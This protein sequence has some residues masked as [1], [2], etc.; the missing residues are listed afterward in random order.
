VNRYGAQSMSAPL[1][2]VAVRRPPTALGDAD[3]AIWHYSA[4]VDVARA[5]DAH[6]V[7]VAELQRCGVEV[8]DIDIDA[9][10]LPDSVFTFDPSLVTERGAVILRMGKQL[11]RPE[12]ELHERYYRSVGV[13]IAGR[14]E[15]PGTVEGGDTLW[16]DETTLAVGRGFRTNDEG[17]DQLSRL[18][19]R[20]NVEVIAFDLPFHDGED[21]CMH[22][23]SLVSPLAADLA[24]VRLPLMPVRLVQLLGDRG[25]ELIDAPAKEWDASASISG[26]VLAVAPR[27][28]LMIDGLPDTRSALQRAGCTVSTFPGDELCL[29][30][31]GGPTC[32][33]R[34]VWRETPGRSDVGSPQGA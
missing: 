29:K 12:A 24:L 27:R 18:L 7:L 6:E 26:N 13:P 2:R 8:D 15:A 22:L 20:S 32:L 21:A 14:I 11:R 3:P 1:R 4:P 28:C 34:P 33:T 17:I 19:A 31:E 25:Y 23:L 5:R 10:A 16:V 9:D 30:A